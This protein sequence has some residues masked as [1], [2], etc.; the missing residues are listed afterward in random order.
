[1]RY[2]NT[3]ILVSPLPRSL[4]RHTLFSFHKTELTPRITNISEFIL[5]SQTTCVVEFRLNVTSFRVWI[6]RTNF[7]SKRRWS[8]FTNQIKIN[9]LFKNGIMDKRDSLEYL[10]QFLDS[11]LLRFCRASSGCLSLTPHLSNQC[12]QSSHFSKQSHIWQRKSSLLDELSVI[13]IG[14]FQYCI[15]QIS[16]PKFKISVILVWDNTPDQCFLN[17]QNWG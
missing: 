3:T 14:T 15:W 7:V 9:H 8:A 11:C 4:K 16:T 17:L 12:Y 10:L 5:I 13:N 2:L 6:Q 1:M